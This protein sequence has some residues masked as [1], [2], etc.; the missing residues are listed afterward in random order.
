V[1]FRP[2]G[3]VPLC[4][5]DGTNARNSAV[6]TQSNL[7]PPAQAQAH[8]RRVLSTVAS[9]AIVSPPRHARKVEVR[10]KQV[11][12]RGLRTSS[13]A[14]T[15]SNRRPQPPV[16][17]HLRLVPST[18]VSRVIASP[19]PPVKKAVAHPKQVIVQG[20]PISNAVPTP[21]NPRPQAPSPQL[22]PPAP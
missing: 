10:L 1:C 12:V 14:H 19:Q 22:P 21:N 7:Q 8:P 18:V 9:K 2:I 3:S 20:L 13:V 11:I 6:P 5:V 15:P 4:S 16:R 17:V